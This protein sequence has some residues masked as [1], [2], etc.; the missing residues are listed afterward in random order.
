MTQ[1]IRGDLSI[2][3][4]TPDN[5]FGLR[6]FVIEIIRFAYLRSARVAVS[7]HEIRRLKLNQNSAVGK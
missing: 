3:R 4:R 5:N 7:P 1:L 6:V 2:R